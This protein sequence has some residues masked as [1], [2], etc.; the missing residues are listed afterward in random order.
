MLKSL[1]LFVFIL[2]TYF[3]KIFAKLNNQGVAA[4]FFLRRLKVFENGK[5][6]YCLE[7]AEIDRESILG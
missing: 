4:T 2:K 5:I 7:I 6:F 3:E 1:W